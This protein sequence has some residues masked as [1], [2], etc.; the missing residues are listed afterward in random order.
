MKE[1][2]LVIP[3]L[4]NNVQKYVQNEMKNLSLSTSFV[5]PSDSIFP[6]IIDEHPTGDLFQAV[7]DYNYNNNQIWNNFM[8]ISLDF[9]R[10]PEYQRF[11][12][13]MDIAG[14]FFYER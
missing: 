2:H 11:F 13:H 7:M 14:G 5:T 8:I 4:W 12:H 3:S 10:S 9:M 6:W 1:S